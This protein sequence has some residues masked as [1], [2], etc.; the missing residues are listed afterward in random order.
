MLPRITKTGPLFL[1]ARALPGLALAQDRPP[2]PVELAKIEI[3]LTDA[4]YTSWEEIEFDD[5]LWEVDDAMKGSDPT[6]YDLKIEPET[7]TIVRERVDD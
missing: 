5:G 2:N 3:A 6:E 4:G 7:W 1:A